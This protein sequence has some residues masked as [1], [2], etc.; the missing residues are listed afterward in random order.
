MKSKKA[1]I[2]IFE[3]V[4]AVLL[5]AGV[6]L[7]IVGRGGTGDDKESLR[8]QDIEVSILR[9][10]ELSN[11]RDVIIDAEPLPIDWVDF[12]SEGLGE[13]KANIISKTPDYLDCKARLC[14]MTDSCVLG[15]DK[16]AE[17]YVQ[18]VVITASLETYSPRQLKL[19]C[20]EK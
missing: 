11:L 1:W 6:L 20:W 12:E 10:I 17:V 5:I 19:F 15:E 3:A 9:E 8:I 13:V 4:I 2:K 16:D 18:S 7:V 14:N